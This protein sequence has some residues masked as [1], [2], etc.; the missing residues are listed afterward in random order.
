MSL[1]RSLIVLALRE[2]FEVNSFKLDSL[3]VTIPAASL[4]KGGTNPACKK[5]YKIS[6]TIS[7]TTSDMI[8]VYQIYSTISYTTSDMILVYQCI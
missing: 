1:I 6:H 3:L 5:S 4:S 7:G 8:S 2:C